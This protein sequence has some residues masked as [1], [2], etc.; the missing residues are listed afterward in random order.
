[1]AKDKRKEAPFSET[2]PLEKPVVVKAKAKV[3]P[4]DQE[5]PEKLVTFGQ[6]FRF[7]RFKLHWAAGMQAYTDTSRRRTLGDWDKLF[8]KY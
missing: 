8:E 2:L 7:K 5:K 3:A 4:K 1:M 6:W